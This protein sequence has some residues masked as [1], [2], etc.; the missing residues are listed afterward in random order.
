MPNNVRG[1][2]G[3]VLKILRV[4]TFLRVDYSHMVDLWW[5]QDAGN[6]GAGNVEK[7]FAGCI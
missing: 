5:A 7:S 3:G 1:V 6:R 2:L 4:I